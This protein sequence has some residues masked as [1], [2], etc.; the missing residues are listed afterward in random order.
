MLRISDESYERVTEI[1]EDIGYCC[2]TEDDYTEWEDI[3]SSSVGSF[4]DELDTEQFKM[5]CE[6]LR[7]SIIPIRIWLWALRRLLNV[8]S[9]SA[10][11]IW[12]DMLFPML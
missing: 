4:M 7:I 12:T 2:V 8:I 9:E 6:A 11:T 3:A 5:T 10:L 1:I